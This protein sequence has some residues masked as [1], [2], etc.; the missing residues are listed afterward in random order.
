MPAIPLIGLAVSAAGA[1][2]TA[3]SQRKALHAQE[4][5]AK[6]AQD[7]ATNGSVNIADV[8]AQAQQAAKDNA[9]NGAALEAQY[10]PGAAQL[11]ANSLAAVNQGLARSSQTQTLADQVAAQA[12]QVPQGIS[13][14]SP[15][16]RDAIAR[17]Q[18]QLALGGTLDTETQNAATRG[19]LAKSGSVSGGL[20]L[21]RDLTA[22]DLGLTSLQLQQ[23]RLTNASNLGGQEAALGQGNAN[24]SLQA[25]QAGTN[26]LFNSANF[27]ASLDSGD[28][29][30]QLSA[31][32]LGQNIAAPASGL[33]PG[34]IANLAV[35]NSTAAAAGLQQA[36]ALQAAGANQKSALG[37]QLIGTG[38]GIASKYFTPAPQYSYAAPA[39]NTTGS[40]YYLGG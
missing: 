6:A 37:G 25:Q 39:N 32:Q 9:A 20:S 2:S 40:S 7:S 11:R 28:F 31:A 14:D 29:A 35:G 24:L 17:A 19:A 23:Q 16:L 1:I 18:S 33:D 15:L 27:L 10:N 13:Y 3:D 34:A 36:A 4:D 12:G 8:Q 5:A 21:G 38:L 30:R 26:N 22:R